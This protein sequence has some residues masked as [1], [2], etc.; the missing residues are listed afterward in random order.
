MC[1]SKYLYGSDY[2]TLALSTE[3]YNNFKSRSLQE[4]EKERAAEEA[5]A[6][7]KEQ[8]VGN[9]NAKKSEGQEP[10]ASKAEILIASISS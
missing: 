2:L 6:A 8:E 7:L 1:I 3:I 10:A 4:I 5:K 9:A